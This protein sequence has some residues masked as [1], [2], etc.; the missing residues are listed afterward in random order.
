MSLVLGANHVCDRRPCTNQT[1][2]VETSG[3]R[4]YEYYIIVE[5]KLTKTT[6]ADYLYSFHPEKFSINVNYGTIN[7]AKVNAPA[8][9]FP[10]ETNFEMYKVY[11]LDTGTDGFDY[12]EFEHFD[13]FGNNPTT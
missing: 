7:P 1:I 6:W 4:T 5:T 8:S 10:S 2:R 3:V 9:I 12:F 13:C 11:E